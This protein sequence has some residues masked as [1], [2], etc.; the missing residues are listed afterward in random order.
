MASLNKVFLVGN[1][2]RDPEL[3]YTPSG[4][5][6]CTFGLAMNRRFVTA[7][8][9]QRE[10]TCFVDIDCWG[11]QGE[12]ASRYLHKGSP[13]LVE[14]R[15][16]YDQ[17]DD[18][19]TGKKRSRLTVSAERI[20][21]LGSPGGSG[22]GD[23]AYQAPPQQAPAYQAPPQ[24]APAYQAPPQ[25]APA[26]Q[27]PPQQA[28]AYQPPAQQAPAASAPPPFPTGDGIDDNIPF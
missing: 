4:A 2:T 1:L 14:G 26:Y 27:A 3:R 7:Q 15:L 23:E 12:T 21:F 28:P 19:D 13:A 11:K 8:G 25:Q 17:W 6:I 22:G 5:A 9:E 10:E 24:Q 20:Q 16:R 18:R